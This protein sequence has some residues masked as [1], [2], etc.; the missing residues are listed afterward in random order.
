MSSSAS[1]TKANG[2]RLRAEERGAQL[3]GCGPDLVRR[4]LIG[5]QLNDERMDPSHVGF[6]GLSDVGHRLSVGVGSVTPNSRLGRGRSDPSSP[7]AS[8]ICLAKDQPVFVRPG[9]GRVRYT[10]PKTAG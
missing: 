7:S 8:G 9:I 6:A 10:T 2:R 5:G 3:I 4:P 1:A